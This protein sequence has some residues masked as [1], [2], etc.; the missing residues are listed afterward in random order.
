MTCNPPS[1]A[2]AAYAVVATG[3]S[4]ETDTWLAASLAIL[5]HGAD[6]IRCRISVLY[7]RV[8]KKNQKDLV[9]IG[10]YMNKSSSASS[11]PKIQVIDGHNTERMLASTTAE[12]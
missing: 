2:G 10:R 12:T 4:S 8:L 5:L 6:I 3:N 11:M 7:K 1:Q 9:H